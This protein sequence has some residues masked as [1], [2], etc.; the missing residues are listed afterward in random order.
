MHTTCHAVCNE[1]AKERKILPRP[2]DML[3]FFSEL[4]IWGQVWSEKALDGRL[5]LT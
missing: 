5:F 1:G 3:S 4:E 2:R